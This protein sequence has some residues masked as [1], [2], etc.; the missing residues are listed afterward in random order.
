MVTSS[1][2]ILSG[3]YDIVKFKGKPQ[4]EGMYYFSYSFATSNNKL[5]HE[6]LRKIHD[7]NMSLFEKV[8]LIAQ[9]ANSIQSSITSNTKGG[10]STITSQK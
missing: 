1:Y 3:E 4:D 5:D 6:Q 10:I 7:G 9:Q 2:K 8:V